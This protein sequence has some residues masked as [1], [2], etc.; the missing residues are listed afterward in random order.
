LGQSFR[1]LKT[2]IEGGGEHKDSKEKFQ[3]VFTE[4]VIPSKISINQKN[5]FAN[6]GKPIYGF[7]ESEMSFSLVDF[8]NDKPK[9]WISTIRHLS[10]EVVGNSSSIINSNLESAKTSSGLEYSTKNSNP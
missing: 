4:K 2:T 8:G 10:N 1:G 6:I 7:I 5:L 9:S 3:D